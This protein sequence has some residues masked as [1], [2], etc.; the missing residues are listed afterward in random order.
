MKSVL[1]L[2]LTLAS[3]S[4]AEPQTLRILCWNIH[5]GAGEDGK[6]DLER[7]AKVI[8]DAKPDLVALQE[9]DNQCSRSGKIDQT[10]ELARLTGMTGVFGKA[11]DFGGGA[12]GQAILSRHPIESQKVHLLPGKGEPRIA[13]QAIV[14]INEFK[15]KFISVHLDLE[16]NQRLAQAK[17]LV[18]LLEKE[19]LPAIL[20]GDFNDQ[21]GSPTLAAFAAPWK[22]VPKQGPPFTSP[23]GKPEHEIDFIFTRRLRHSEPVVVLPEAVASDHRPLLGQF[24]IDG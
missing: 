1:A 5:H 16:A 23:A 13:F 18:G 2:L 22:L 21:P 15:L 4:A 10:A 20:C 24:A 14:S 6:L 7:I 17:T 9:V 11:M 19:A 3:I 8:T 12:Y